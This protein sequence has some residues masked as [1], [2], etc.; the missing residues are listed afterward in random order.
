[1]KKRLEKIE[2][3]KTKEKYIVRLYYNK[4][5]IRQIERKFQ[6]IFATEIKTK[7]QFL[8]IKDF[9][10]INIFNFSKSFD[11]KENKIEYLLKSKF[12]YDSKQRN[13]T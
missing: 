1:M 7:W 10:K 8:N 12:T 9:K 13:Y 11:R 6:T 4:T 5:F 2:I 3:F